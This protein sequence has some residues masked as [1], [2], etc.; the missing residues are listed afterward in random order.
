VNEL[1]VRSAGD[2][3]LVRMR[4]NALVDPDTT[5]IGV[6]VNRGATVPR[7][8]PLNAGVRS[9]WDTFVTV[10][11]HRA[12][13]D[14]GDTAPAPVD[15]ADNTIEFTIPGA[16]AGG[17]SVSLVAGAG[18][19]DADIDQ[20]KAGI[21]GNAPT[22]T[23]YSTGGISAVRV[24]DLAFNANDVEPEGGNWREDAQAKAL[25][26]AQVGAFSQAIDLGK[27][28]AGT[29]D[30]PITT[31]G[32]YDRIFES[33]QDL[34]EGVSGGFPQYKSRFQTYGLWIP[35]G[36][37]P[38]APAP[39]VLVLHSLSVH[40]NQYAG[41]KVY[42]HLGDGLN[43]VA[44]TPLA[45]GPDGW[46]WNEGLVDTLE[47]WSDVRAHYAIDDGRTYA[48]GYSMGGYAAYRL[49]TLMPDRFGGAV[50][51]VGPP[52][53]QIW[54]WPLDPIG[55]GGRQVSGNTYH[56]LENTEHIPFF[57]V[58]GTNDELVPTEG[59]LHQAER[60]HELGYEYR[61]N[62][63]P[64]VDH[65][66]LVVLDDWTRERDWLDGRTLVRDPAH[67]T[68]LVRPN[69][70]ADGPNAPTLLTELEDLGADLNSAYWVRDVVSSGDADVALESRGIAA[71]SPYLTEVLGAAA[72][73]PTPY[74]QRGLDR[75]LVDK[76]TADELTGRVTG[77]TELTIDVGRA[78]LTLG[79]RVD[80]ATDR[81]LVVHLRDGATIVDVPVAP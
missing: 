12:I 37:D 81:D 36:Y 70:W 72:G 28:A 56:M 68:F 69:A 26:S 7:D 74:L 38:S 9:A 53:Y 77:A 79:A 47:A 75:A 39:L 55:G 8:W 64:G 52:A 4:M 48:T 10:A 76:F 5:A 66:A 58:H 45:R 43:A 65:L 62:L 57:I 51:W 16:A 13:L 44:M 15:L 33:I 50:S 40:H 78:G 20:W 41:S 42:R 29:T 32:F 59:V 3:L 67:V 49:S 23:D 21:A 1:R 31:A 17:G 80:I 27:L 61:Y 6:G 18:L 11:E 71:R 19:W 2:D 22:E 73:P 34:G 35:S 30:P 25:G 24:F 14:N 60:F 63:H 46:Y 54:A